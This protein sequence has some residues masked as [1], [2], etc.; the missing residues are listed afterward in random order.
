MLAAFDAGQI[1][2]FN[3][4]MP[5]PMVP[6]LA[7]KA[8]VIANGTDGDPPDMVPFAN[9]LVIVRAGDCEKRAWLCTGIG[10]AMSDAAR[11]VHEHPDDAL[12]LL[13]KRFPTLDP[14]L[15]AAA[16]QSMIKV[17]PVPPA[18]GIAELAN[19]ER[20]NIEAGAFE[21]RGQARL[22]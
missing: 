14:K 12:A 9:T 10:G 5:W 22:L 7:G 1:D 16:F 2:G 13:T 20:L 21:A 11:Y 18:P 17:T 3:M 4:S 19:A 15:V 8:V 6:A